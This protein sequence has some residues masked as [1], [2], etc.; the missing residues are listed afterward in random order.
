[1]TRDEVLQLAAD[2]IYLADTASC[3]CDCSDC[4]HQARTDAENVL[5]AFAAK[6]IVLGTE[7]EINEMEEIDLAHEIHLG[8]REDAVNPQFNALDRL[9]AK[10]PSVGLALVRVVPND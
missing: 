9:T 6:G 10:L 8:M 4:E 2:A 1:M 5:A 7:P 3:D